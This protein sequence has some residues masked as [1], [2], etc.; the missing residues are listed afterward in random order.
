MI[1]V[2]FARLAI[3]SAAALPLLVFAAENVD[4]SIVHPSKPKLSSTPK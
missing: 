4:L 2:R 3:A 1:R